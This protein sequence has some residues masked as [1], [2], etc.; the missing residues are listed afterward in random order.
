[1]YDIVVFEGVPE[2]PVKAA[3]VLALGAAGPASPVRRIGKTGP[4]RFVDAQDSPL[5]RGVDLDEVYVDSGEKVQPVGRGRVVAESDQGPLVVVA[6]G[7]QRQVYL[8][9]RPLDSDFPLS[10]GFPIFVANALTFLAGAEGG[11]DL[12]VR[13]GQSFAVGSRGQTTASL[14]GPD[15]FQTT[16]A[17]KDGRFLVPG[18]ARVGEY[19]LTVGQRKTTVHAVLRSDEESDV[20]PRDAIDLP[21]GQVAATQASERLADV[22][23]W[24]VLLGL[25]VLGAEWWVFAR[26]S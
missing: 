9:F 15:G 23:K 18:L 6:E 10:V 13:P 20:Q 19:V 26:R 7:K 14:T 17:A 1:V 3:G 2:Q 22:W 16:V 12:L 11:S 5:M 21:A 24:V 8:A 4:Q 25:L